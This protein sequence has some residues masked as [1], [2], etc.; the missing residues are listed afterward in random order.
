MDGYHLSTFQLKRKGIASIRGA[1]QTFDVDGFIAALSRIRAPDGKTVYVPDY[2]RVL[3]EPI[4]ASLAIT[5]ETN[6]VVVEGNYLLLEAGEW[7]NVWSHLTHGWFLDVEWAV[8]RQ[9]LIARHIGSGKSLAAATEWVDRS[10][11]ANYDLIVGGSRTQDVR[12]CR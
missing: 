2:S 1:P 6:V 5:A 8:C 12:F 3:D 10:D 7:Q 4:A 9:R 11:K